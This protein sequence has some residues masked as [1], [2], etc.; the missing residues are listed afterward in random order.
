[1]DR[2]VLRRIERLRATARSVAEGDL[3]ARVPLRGSDELTEL[4]ADF[5]HMAGAVEARIAEIREFNTVLEARVAERTTELAAAKKG[6]EAAN[7][8]KSAFLSNMSH[9][10]RTPLNAILGLTHLLCNEA[11]PMQADRLGKI[12]AAGKHL[13]SIIN[14]ILDISK[15]EAGKLQ[16]EQR[17]FSL[18]DV[19]DHVRA[20]LGET[21]RAKGLE[22]RIEADGVPVWLRGDVMR[23]RQAVL[24]Y[25]GNA[26]KFTR[27]GH[28]TLAAQLLDERG[29]E[30]LIRFS[31]S[32]SGV[33]I[34]AER[35]PLLFE[36]FAQA[37]AS[38]TREFGGT[39]LGL[40]ITRRLAE[41]MGG[42][43]GAE[44]APGQGSTFWFTARMQRGRGIPPQ[45]TTP[46]VDAERQLRERPSP[47]RLLLAEDNFIN[48]EVALELLH[49]VRLAVDVAEDGAIAVERARERRYDLVLMDVQMPNLDGLNATRAIR[50]LPGWRDVPILAMTANAFDEDR[51]DAELA[52]MNDHVAKP[53]DPDQLF[54]TLVKWLPPSGAA[55]GVREAA[56]AV[57]DGPAPDERLRTRLE[58]IPDLDFA[59]GLRSVNGRLPS[60][61]RLLEIFVETHAA[62]V[63]R[64]SELVEQGNLVAAGEIVHTLK[65]S[66]GNIGATVICG[67]VGEL[68]AAL[69]TGDRIAAQIALVPLAERFLM[70]T[71]ALRVALSPGV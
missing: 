51:Q 1:M 13:L 6:A 37:D 26:L 24:N 19:L 27:Q 48:R 58:A 31:V 44:S 39:G 3:G 5:N 23:L 70:L 46:P 16:L 52:G 53:V 20:I 7:E 69:R 30:L 21:A 59:A 34:E 68:D 54:A 42:N 22:I 61:L 25:A 55:A 49:S 41:L 50:Q 36:S 65:G 10:I 71:K 33:G 60:Y 47:A 38:T 12:D 66:V 43:A 18:S 64:V 11:T 29:D 35:L 14:D 57:P 63:P 2:F 17:D 45:T 67:M 4:G 28:I 9:E 32:D 62:S 15:I 8:A 40:S 56:T